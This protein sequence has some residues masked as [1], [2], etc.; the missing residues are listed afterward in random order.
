MHVLFLTSNHPSFHRGT[1][2]NVVL[3]SLIETMGHLGHRVSWATVCTEDA[4]DPETEQRLEGVG[5]RYFADFSDMVETFNL[6]P[7]W[8]TL[9]ILR[10][11]LFPRV[12]DDYPQFR[13]PRGAARRLM[14]SGADAV[15]LFWDTWF[16]HLLPAIDGIPT[17]VYGARPRHAAPLSRLEEGEGGTG[18]RA[19]LRRWIATR[20]L[21]HQ[22]ARRYER[23]KHASRVV[24]ISPVDVTE[25]ESNGVHCEYLPNTWPDDVGKEWAQK[26]KVAEARDRTINILGNMSGVT[27]SGNLFGM[28]YLASQILPLLNEVL[29]N[30]EWELNITGGGQLPPDLENF[31][32]HPCV[33][34]KGY[35][36]DIEEEIL[37]N[38]I[39]LLCNNAGPLPGSYTRVIYAMSL[40]ACL[41]GHK[42]LEAA[43]PEVKSNYNTLLGENARAIAK[44]IEN[45][46]RDPELRNRISS[47]ARITYEQYFR[48]EIVARRLTDLI[49]RA[50]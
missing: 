9:N 11:G 5:A 1:A 22:A 38:H 37:G 31:F 7:P 45:A 48:P 43:M 40:G 39:F 13:D 10:R 44:L 15:I 16:E 33:K 23:L 35:V 3:A 29:K 18:M 32:D 41:I 26:R 2:V 24:N 17:V 28:R 14:D 6:T 50:F 30:V 12:N 8:S 47:N 20:L 46:I 27:Q 34:V 42:N 21:S 36:P 25:C 19:G 49:E 4:R